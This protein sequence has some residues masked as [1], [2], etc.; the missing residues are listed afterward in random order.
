M[1]D[2]LQSTSLITLAQE[3][4]GDVV[5]NINRRT[6]ALK[7]L[8]V[9]QGSGK[10]IAW[11][12]ETSGQLAE[13][14]A[15]GADA[16]NFGSDGQLAAVLPW[17][18]YRGNF[19]VSNLAMDTSVTA[20]TPVGNRMLWARNLVNASAA[21]AQLLNQEIYAGP[22]TGTRMAGLSVAIG[23]TTNT[24]AGLLRTDSDKALFRPTVIDPGSSTPVTFALIRDDLRQIYEACGETPDI[25]LCSPAVFNAVGNLFDQNRRYV[26]SV[27]TAKGKIDLSFGYAGIEVDG[28][29]FVKD[30]DSTAGWIHYINSN[31]MHIEVLPPSSSVGPAPQ[32]QADDGFGPAPLGFKYELLAKTGPSEKAEV[33]S[34]LNLVVDRPNAH[35]VRKNVA[36]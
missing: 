24:Y 28:T 25:A 8:K 10:N 29:V 22:G 36:A 26:Q 34:S 33:L 3:Y 9:V 19:H 5:R 21:L 23:S 16:A 13:N 15:E 27:E 32:I 7:L 6:M 35:G 1:S 18:L 14:Y 4:R 20:S 12:P 11:A 17:A 30:K 31:H 2:V